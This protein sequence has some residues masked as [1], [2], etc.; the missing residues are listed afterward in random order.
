MLKQRN[1]QRQTDRQT[2][3]QPEEHI[4][5]Q[6]LTDLLENSEVLV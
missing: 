4:T 2:G 1:R 6:T 5:L 3:S